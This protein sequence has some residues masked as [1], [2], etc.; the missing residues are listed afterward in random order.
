M[1]SPPPIEVPTW[2]EWYMTM[3]YLAAMKSKDRRTKIGAVV[4]GPDREV[5]STGFNGIPRGVD[6]GVPDR[7]ERP[8]KHMWFEHAERNAIYNAARPVLEGCT[9]YVQCMPCP[10]CARGII[11]SGIREIVVHD[12]GGSTCLRGEERFERSMQMLKEASVGVR[13]YG[14]RIAREIKGLMDGKAV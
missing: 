7:Q 5:R 11:Q 1:G 9:M 12:V 10:D 2:D 14:G 4:V 6:D 13:T 3:A 8:E